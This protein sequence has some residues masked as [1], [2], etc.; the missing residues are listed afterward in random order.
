VVRDHVDDD[1]QTASVRLVDQVA[2]VVERA[3]HRI[4]IARVSDVVA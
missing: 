1:P 4:D 3:V 2:R